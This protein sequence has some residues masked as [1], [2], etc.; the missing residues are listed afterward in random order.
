MIMTAETEPGLSSQPANMNQTT[1]ADNLMH[2]KALLQNY[3]RYEVEFVKGEGAYLYDTNDKKYYDF[4]SGIAVT[5]FGHNHPV[6][7]AAVEEQLNKL[8]HVSNLFESTP[9]EELAKKLV[10]SSG[11]DSV[12]FCNSGTEANEAAI[13]FAR[14]WGK[15]RTQII[16]ASGGFHGRTMGSLS[17]T[18]QPKLWEGFQPMTPGFIHVPF[19][20]I[21]AVKAAYDQNVAAIMVEPVQGESGIVV[22]PADYLNSL[23][24][25]C[26]EHNILLIFDEVQSGMGRTG[27][28]FA[29]QWD[30]VKAD[31]IT[32]AKGIANGIP[33]G[34]T[35][36]R[37]D[38]A[39]VMV[40]G[41]HGSTF[42]GNP[43][44]IAAGNAVADLLNENMLSEI[45]A[46][47]NKLM[48]AIVSLN[49]DKIKE[50]RGKGLMIGIE[51][52]E[53]ISAKKV[54]SKLLAENVIVGT[55]GDTVLRLLPPFIITEKEILNFV[56]A[57]VN[58]LSRI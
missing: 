24:E 56:L 39:E 53:G 12:F 20:D 7:K 21:E 15:E 43:L 18:G 9:Q 40:P 4:L 6:I 48:N 27:K 42:G 35:I 26:D 51:F 5:G 54:A 25:F 38:I 47:G 8:W 49:T 22:P 13:K 46:I 16:T 50:V 33:L 45:Y 30:G 19:G 41:T 28:F 32:L 14:K 11:L 37:Y 2:G 1:N 3:A 57:L 58:V 55:S 44:A 17:A 10:R 23:R 52:K 36:C 31:I 34:A 29:H